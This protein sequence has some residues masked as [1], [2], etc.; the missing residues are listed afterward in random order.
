MATRLMLTSSLEIR[1]QE[2]GAIFWYKLLLLHRIL[3]EPGAILEG[4]MM[5]TSYAV[6]VL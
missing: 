3:P 6:S 2:P 1:S 5:V 4:E